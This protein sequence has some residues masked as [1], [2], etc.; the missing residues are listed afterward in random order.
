MYLDGF[1]VN[2]VPGRESGEYVYMQHGSQYAVHLSNTSWAKRAVAKVKIDGK[3]VGN[4]ILPPGTR[5]MGIERSVYSNGIF[6][7]AVQDSLMGVQGGLGEV[8]RNALGLIEVQFIPEKL[9]P[10]IQYDS[11]V[12]TSTGTLGGGRLESLS[13]DSEPRMKGMGQRR[14]RAGGTVETGQSNQQFVQ[15]DSFDL[16]YSSAVTIYLRLREEIGE[17]YGV[18]PLH[19]KTTKYPR[20]I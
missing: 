17:N 5:Q 8:E 3:E 2:I 12:F 9:R 13:N 7:F 6:T 18:R 4:F 15:G 14:S 1:A 20:P 19:G 11:A 10:A 16:D